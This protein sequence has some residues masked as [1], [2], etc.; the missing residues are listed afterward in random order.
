[1]PEWRALA[2]AVVLAVIPA[3]PPRA[4]AAAT[5]AVVMMTDTFEF[6]PRAVTVHAGDAVEWRNASRFKH[7]VTADPALGS[8]ALPPGAQPFASGE[9]Q[10][11]ESFRH[12]LSVPG[13]YRYFCTPHEGIGM[14]GTITVLPN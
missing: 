1:M 13:T 6:D 11:G 10:P 4:A 12:V 7:S 5:T 2:A 8:A 9:L 14:T 3:A